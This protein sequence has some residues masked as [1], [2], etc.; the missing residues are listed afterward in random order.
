MKYRNGTDNE[1]DLE[2]AFVRGRRGPRLACLRLRPRSDSVRTRGA[3]VEEARM[4]D[5][6]KVDLILGETTIIDWSDSP[7]VNA[8]HE[9]KND[10]QMNASIR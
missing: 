4:E 9:R 8:N 7:V 10:V 1:R 5:Q 6:M 2:F 3:A